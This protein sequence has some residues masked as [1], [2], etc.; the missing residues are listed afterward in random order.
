MGRKARKGSAGSPYAIADYRS[1]DP[2]LGGE[3]GF[4][5]FLDEAHERGLRL[6]I[7]VVYNHTSPDSVLVREHP[8]WF[9]KGP[10]GRPAP[11]VA[12]W[13]RPWWTSTIR[14]ATSGT[15]R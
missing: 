8:E 1:V 6:I 9:W 14:S 13:V 15:T 10:G 2:A 11:R 3:E 4:R 5:R 7:D 12:E